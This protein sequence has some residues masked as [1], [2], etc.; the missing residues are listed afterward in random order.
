MNIEWLL[1]MIKIYDPDAFSPQLF[2]TAFRRKLL[3]AINVTEEIDGSVVLSCYICPVD[4]RQ[5]KGFI[6][7][8]LTGTT[9]GE[10]GLAVILNH[11][12]E[13]IHTWWQGA[14]EPELMFVEAE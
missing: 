11:M 8:K 9:P 12:M 4:D 13:H 6:Y 14:K 2:D 10:Y 7:A 3:E 5:H 1:K